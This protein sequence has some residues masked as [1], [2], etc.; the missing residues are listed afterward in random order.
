[1]R[2]KYRYLDLRRPEMQQTLMLRSKAAKVFRDF[3]DEQRLHR[4]RNADS[5]EEHAGRRAR[6]SGAE[7]RASG[8]ILRAAAVAA[9]FQAAA[10]GRRARALLPDRPLLP[11]RGSARRPSAGVHPGR[12]RDVVP[13]AG[14]VARHDGGAGRPSCSRRRSASRCRASVPAHHLCRMRWTNTARTSRIL[15]FGLEMVDIT[16]IVQD[17]DV[18]VFA[19]WLQAAASSRR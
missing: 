7:P 2:L 14:S 16:D 11:R 8:R 1:M 15:R 5:D 13:V 17:S 10:H 9:D 6:L 3:L 4:D 12:H 18:K 19:R